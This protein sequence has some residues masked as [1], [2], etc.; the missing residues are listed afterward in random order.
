MSRLPTSALASLRRHRPAA[1]RDLLL[2]QAL[3]HVGRHRDVHHL[4]IGQV[5]V[6]HQCDVFVDRLHLQARI[7]AL[8]LA[9]R[10]DRVAF[11]VVRREHHRFV[12]QAQQAVEDRL[13]LRA[14]IAVL[15]IG[16]AG[17]ADQQRVAGEH[18]VRHDEAVGIVGMAG[19][20]GDIEADALDAEP[21]AVGDAHRH[22]VD[23]GLLAHH[24][25]AARPVAQRAEAGDVIGVQMR[26]DRLHQLQV[27]LADELQV[28]ID[29]LQ[30]RIDDQRLA[31]AA[32]RKQ[33]GVG[34]GRRVEQL[35]EDHD[36]LLRAQQGG[37]FSRQQLPDAMLI[38][39]AHAPGRWPRAWGV[40]SPLRRRT[41]VNVPSI[42]IPSSNN[43]PGSGTAVVVI[44]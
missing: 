33:V 12:G 11:V 34:A 42:P 7:V 40:A 2:R 43:E 18:P 24:G 29:L 5:Q 8:L 23:A 9:D 17:A 20:I 38:T 36:H 31:A 41:A 3:A 10:A 30:H 15:E 39:P 26:I 16:A 32:G 6:V 25:D 13:V 14:R 35:A 27:E 44:E 1:A 37:E 4:R 19:R 28:A 21:V 22:H